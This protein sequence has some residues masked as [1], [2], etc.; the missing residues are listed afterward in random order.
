MTMAN[1]VLLV[2]EKLDKIMKIDECI[3]RD[4]ILQRVINM[5]VFLSIRYR[6]DEA[7]WLGNFPD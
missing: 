1:I 3:L 7:S 4:T 2:R 5:N 6:N